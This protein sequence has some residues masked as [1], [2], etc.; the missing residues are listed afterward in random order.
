LYD[1]RA[2]LSGISGRTLEDMD[3]IW[4]D[5]LGRQDQE[6]TAAAV[7]RL[8]RELAQL[9]QRVSVVPKKVPEE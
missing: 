1:I 4:G 2:F 8:E 5:D 3:V 9:A 7:S 6:R